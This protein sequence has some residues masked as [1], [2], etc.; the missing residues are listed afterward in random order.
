MKLSCRILLSLVVLGWAGCTIDIPANTVA[1]PTKAAYDVWNAT[2]TEMRRYDGNDQLLWI[3]RYSTDDFGN[4]V[5]NHYS[6]Q[7]KLLW[8]ELKRSEPFG[9]GTRVTRPSR[10][11]HFLPTTTTGI[12]TAYR[13]WSY[14]S[15][16][17][18]V[19]RADYDAAKVLTGYSHNWWEVVPAGRRNLQ[20]T[21]L[22]SSGTASGFDLYAYGD[23][24]HPLQADAQVRLTGDLKYGGI[25]LWTR[26]LANNVTAEYGNADGGTTWSRVIHDYIPGTLAK[27]RQIWSTGKTT[28]PVA[29]AV[30]AG[31]SSP[32]VAPTAA[33]PAYDEA[34]N[35]TDPLNGIALPDLSSLTSQRVEFPTLTRPST[36]T[37]TQ[38]EYYF[39]DAKGSTT[40][41]LDGK[42]C[43]LYIERTEP[44][45]AT[46]RADFV[47]DTVGNLV[48]R[49]LSYGGV[50]LITFDLRRD[51]QGRIVSVEITGSGIKLPMT[52]GLTYDGATNRPTSLTVS[53][54]SLAIFSLD[55]TYNTSGRRPTSPFGLEALLFDDSIQSMTLNVG[56]LSDK[57]PVLQLVFHAPVNLVGSSEDKVVS[58][59]DVLGKN[60]ATKV[61]KGRLAWTYDTST[62]KKTSFLWQTRNSDGSFTTAWR[63]TA[64]WGTYASLPAGVESVLVARGQTPATVTNLL[65]DAWGA[66]D[67]FDVDR[68][69]QLVDAVKGQAATAQA[70]Y[71]QMAGNLV[72]QI[73]SAS[74]H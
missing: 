51:T 24:S 12:P 74:G 1:T 58:V 44:G 48:Q 42:G 41:R 15:V 66:S 65:S 17:N 40:I 7:D 28:T 55:F 70:Q 59:Y 33:V 67:S 16:G 23:A 63:Y 13:A 5:K 19:A 34:A 25:N 35:P 4:Q 57:L 61:L 22:G 56:G 3:D 53:T 72:D 26:D 11:G 68:L 64:A 30:K 14:D 50:P 9:V 47:Y 8:F 38:M 45:L 18:E 29:K 49:A 62:G 52:Y 43:P 31:A 6:P 10:W 60:D 69:F 54:A 46:I 71:R 32:T 2:E 36:W 27:F 73:R 39:S 20:S 21:Q 37:D